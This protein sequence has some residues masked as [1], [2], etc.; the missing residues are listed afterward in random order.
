[1]NFTGSV[2]AKPGV[3]P[4]RTLPLNMLASPFSRSN[5]TKSLENHAI[6]RVAHPANKRFDS[7]SAGIPREI[8]SIDLSNE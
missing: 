6:S 5:Q 2:A 3:S 7:H 8:Q 4:S 1:M